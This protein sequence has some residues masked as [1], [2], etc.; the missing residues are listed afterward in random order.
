MM[1]IRH[2]TI[3]LSTILISFLLFLSSCDSGGPDVSDSDF[4]R[5]EMN[6]NYG[7]NI[8]LPSYNALQEDVNNLQNA[9]NAFAENPT[10]GNLSAA[11]EE[12]K[13][14]RLAW[15]DANLFQFGPA[16]SNALRTSVNTFP[17]DTAQ[18]ES[19]ID[20]G[21][22]TLGTLSN[23]SAAGFPTLGY[24]LHGIGNSSEE[25][26]S[27]Y[28]DDSN[29]QNRIQYL[30]D[31]ITFISNNIDE[32]AEEW[33]QGGGDFISDFVSEENAGT[34]VG[35]SLGQLVNA[36]VLHHERFIRDGKIG[37]PAGVRSAGVPR[38]EA[39]EAFYAGYSTELAIAN[40]KAV[41]RLFLGNNLNNEEGLGLDD[42][43]EAL[44]A[45]ELAGQMVTDLDEA[46]ASLENLSDPLSEN[47]EN[48]NDPVLD[49]FSELQDLV[50]LMKADMASIL[51]VTITFQDNDGD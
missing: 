42:N 26:V 11:R 33:T 25:I 32:V 36:L 12:L 17:A 41:K 3:T 51:G 5:I 6:E 34:D 18:I 8:I 19:N 38:P 48:N 39:T 21:D 49:T 4:D 27:R 15:Q 7:N 14:A 23:Q 13:K 16:E 30:Q 31:N 29:A 44:D 43:L 1:N 10:V 9:V 47:I 45:S 35:S 20:S 37:I 2:F 22:Y 40:T 28:V 50:V 46:V 24:L